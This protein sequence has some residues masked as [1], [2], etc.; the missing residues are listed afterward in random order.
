MPRLALWRLVLAG[1]L[2]LLFVS[3]AGEHIV[4]AALPLMEKVFVLAAPDFRVLE[5]G[6]VHAQSERRIAVVATL[7]RTAVVGSRVLV[8]NAKGRAEAI[9]PMAHTLH[10]G[11]LALLIASAWPARHRRELS[12]RMAV[13]LPLAAALVVLDAPLVLAASLWQLLRDALAPNE[14]SALIG[15]SAF[16]R[17]GGRYVLAVLAAAAAIEVCKPR[18]LHA[19][20]RSVARA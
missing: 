20:W 13:A 5:F 6:V 1:G 12:W 10:G 17:G 15:L 14:T 8:P 7:R 16:L 4:R 18:V 11:A 2:V 19:A 9:T 3:L